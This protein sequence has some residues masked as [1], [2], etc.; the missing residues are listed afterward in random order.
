MS[1]DCSALRS[2][3]KEEVSP[4]PP[5][6][7]AQLRDAIIPAAM[8][9]LGLES[10]GGLFLYFSAAFGAF[11]V[12]LWL[13]LAFWTW[14]D[15]RARSNDRF[16]RV[17]APLLVFLLSLPGVIVYLILR[18]RLTLEEE[19][20]RALEEEA[21]LVGIEEQA[22]CPGC[23]R[24]AD[25]EWQICPHCHTRLRKACARCGRLLDLPWNLCP[26]CGTPAQ[27]V[28]AETPAEQAL[29]T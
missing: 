3:L 14:R 4:N 8:P 19:Y 9:N 7:R 15:I 29:P 11:L 28:R 2:P 12:A 22:T 1:R 26:Y 6:A 18:P 10:L 25:R 21:L 13:S 27:P 5:S 17:L 20:E 23:S 24:R 16:L